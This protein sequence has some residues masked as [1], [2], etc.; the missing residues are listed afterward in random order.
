MAKNQELVLGFFENE[1]AAENAAKEL[2][3]M[4]RAVKGIKFDNIGILVKDDKGKIKTQKLGKRH[5]GAGIALGGI[6]AVMTG[7]AS[8]LAG[9]AIGGA[10]GH[11]A[12]KGLGM[13]KDDLNR[14]SSELDGG[15]AAVG[16][17]VHESEAKAVASWMEGVG[18]KPESYTVSEEAVAEAVAEAEAAPAEAAATETATEAASSNPSET[19]SATAGS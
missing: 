3:D 16:I 15:K 1:T 12:Q 17:L 19:P 2:Q 5:T 9:A 14:I 18:G 13:S 6:A 11:F 8:L 10:I 4:D 7:G